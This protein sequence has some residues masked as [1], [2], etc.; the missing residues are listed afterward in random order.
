M[1]SACKYTEHRQFWPVANFNRTANDN[2]SESTGPIN[3][4]LN[5]TAKDNPVDYSTM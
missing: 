1:P 3:D 5:G 2:R 4:S